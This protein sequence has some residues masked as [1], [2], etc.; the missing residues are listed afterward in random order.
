MINPAG[1][2]RGNRGYT[3][4][5][6]RSGETVPAVV[7]SEENTLPLHSM[8]DPK[9]E[10]QRLI[11][12]ISEDTGFI[13]FLGLGGGFAPEA[14]L[15]DTN[16]QVVVIDF[17]KDSITELLS[18][19]DY[20]A[21]LNN[22][23]FRLLTDPSCGEIKSIILENYNPSLCGSIKTIPLR[24]RIEQ[25]IKLFENA[26]AEIQESIEVVSSDYSVQAHFGMRWFSNI[27]RNIKIANITNESLNRNKFI[28]SV[29]EAAIVA[30]GP[31]LDQQIRL[32]AEC[33]HMGVF[34][35]STDTALPVLL[36]NGI[37][38]DT[39]VSI[40]CQH[41][42]YYHFIGC[43]LKSGIT[44][45]L[46]I[47]S[48]P[49]LSGFSSS[50][51]FFSGGHPLARYVST[52][53]QPLP[54]IDT[55]GGN[56]TYAC[57]SLAEY[58]GAN[59]ITLFGAD[60]SYIGSKTYARGTYIYPFFEKKQN[61]FSP[62]QSLLSAFLYRSPFLPKEKQEQNYRETASLRM[63]RN[64]FEEKAATMNAQITAVSGQGAPISLV[65]KIPD[66]AKKTDVFSTVSI[67]EKSGVE[68]LEQYKEDIAA[69][70]AADKNYLSRLNAKDR[71]IFT[72]L[73]PCLA[74]IRHRRAD[75]K[76]KDSIEET[77]RF[78]IQKI[79]SVLKQ[80]P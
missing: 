75:L 20:S 3:F 56:V 43:N 41:I 40:D 2:N 26:A 58:L 64:K 9:R 23:R 47:A 27:I 32:L 37:I 52:V 76:T 13:I 49:L 68:F 22:E 10:A 14:A 51:V 12:T 67:T 70:P 4:L 34:V 63:Y 24:P 65:Q 45:V 50:P 71:Q 79:I 15:K 62:A 21:L 6:S 38:P 25:D 36:R 17:H 77:K 73:L 69:L 57:L 11:S 66:N 39:V 42:S 80:K 1:K 72:T 5:K 18:S 31:S 29:Q 19:K 7:L 74:A 54:P 30:A 60:F 33:K 55:S 48:P 44:L 61:R 46:D 35:I 28:S 53:W 59:R 16:A 78:C 8:V